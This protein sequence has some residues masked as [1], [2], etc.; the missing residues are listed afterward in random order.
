MTM[1]KVLSQSNMTL[2]SVA[3]SL[4]SLYVSTA[5]AQRDEKLSAFVAQYKALRPEGL[6]LWRSAQTA[7]MAQEARLVSLQKE[8][9]NYRKRLSSLSIGIEEYNLRRQREQRTYDPDE[10]HTYLV[11]ARAADALGNVL[12]FATDYLSVK[13]AVYLKVAFKYEEGW[14]AL[15]ELV[16]E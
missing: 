13:K 8:I 9:F 15:D 14:R 5:H 3:L 1:R 12:A 6:N 11:V 10:E 16:K 7:D 4:I 2:I